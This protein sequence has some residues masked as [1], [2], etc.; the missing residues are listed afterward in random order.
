MTSRSRNNASGMH[1]IDN[2]ADVPRQFDGS[3]RAGNIGTKSGN[4]RLPASRQ[5]CWPLPRSRRRA[6]RTCRE[7]MPQPCALLRRGPFGLQ[8]SPC[9]TLLVVFDVGEA[10]ILLRCTFERTAVLGR[11][12]LNHFFDLLGQFEILVGYSLGRVVL[13]AHLDPGV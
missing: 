2:A 8:S 12:P 10:C 5:Q 1:V 3:A 6:G 4:D 13:Q 9:P 7:S 11:L